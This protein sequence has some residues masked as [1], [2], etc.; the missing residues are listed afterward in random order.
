MAIYNNYIRACASIHLIIILT[1]WLIY[2]I[3]NK[4][5]CLQ[6]HIYT[7]SLYLVSISTLQ[8]CCTLLQWCCKYVALQQ[9]LYYSIIFPCLK[10]FEYVR[11]VGLIWTQEKEKRQSWNCPRLRQWDKKEYV[12]IFNVPVHVLIFHLPP[13]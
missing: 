6:T 1:P 12:D 11:K 7:L 3:Y 5:L 8:K 10:W 9:N 4:T 2:N 13:Q